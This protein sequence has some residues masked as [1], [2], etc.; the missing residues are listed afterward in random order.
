RLS[1]QQSEPNWRLHPFRPT[2]QHIWS[3]LKLELILPDV[4]L[5]KRDEPLQ[6]VRQQVKLPF[7]FEDW[8]SADAATQQAKLENW[9]LSDRAQKF[10]LTQA[11]LMRVALIQLDETDYQFVWS[12]HH[13]VL[14]A[15]SGPL[16]FETFFA[17]YQAYC[18]QKS[19]VLS[20]SRPYRDYIRWLQQQ[21][22][23]QAQTFWQNKLS[24]I[25]GPTSLR[26]DNN[27]MPDQPEHWNEQTL[28]LSST[29]TTGLYQ[30]AQKNQLTVSTLIQGV[31]AIL[32]SRY[33][34]ETDVV[35][36]NAVSGRTANLPGIE[37]M[38]GLFI[39]MLP[40]RATI[41]KATPVLTW[42]KAFQIAQSESQQ[43]EYTPLSKI[44]QWSDVPAGKSLFEHILLITNIVQEGQNQN[45]NRP[46]TMAVTHIF[47]Q[48]N[49]P[50]SIRV[51]P[52]QQLQWKLSYDCNRFTD[53]AI[54]RLLEHLEALAEN[55][56]GDPTQAIGHLDWITKAERQ[57]ILQDW[58]ATQQ[59][60]LPKDTITQLFEAQAAKT[61][62]AVAVVCD[63]QQLT[64]AALNER[65]NQLA[66][67]LR[68]QG[69]RSGDIVAILMPRS[70]DMLV[71]LLATLKAGAT[72]LP[73]DATY[74]PDRL[75][76]MLQD[77]QASYLLSQQT[78]QDSIP[79][80]SGQT[81]FLDAAQDALSQASPH[82]LDID[83][84]SESLAYVI[85]TS[86]STGKPKGVQIPHR[87]LTN[88]LLSMQQEPGITASDTLLSV[89]TIAFDISALELY[90]PLISGAKVIILNQAAASV[91]EQ[92]IAALEQHQ[93]TLM[94]ATP[95]TWR[96][97][98]ESG[99]T[100]HST[101][102]ILCGGEALK[103]D[104]ATKLQPKG[105]ALWNM[106]GPTE[107]TIW[108]AISQITSD[109]GIITIGRP[110]A[111]TELFILDEQYQP[112]P[113][114]IPGTLYIGGAGLAQGYLNRPNLTSE[115]F[116]PHPFSSDPVAKIYNTGDL[117]RY[118][119]DGRVECLG[120]IDHQVKIRGFRIELEEISAILNQHDA[121][122][123][124]VIHTHTEF[125]ETTLV[126]Y[127]VTPEQAQP[128]TAD[129]RT[130][131]RQSLP[132]YMI[133]TTFMRL[134]QL[135]LTPNGKIDRKALPKPDAA[136]PDL[137]ETYTPPTGDIEMTIAKIWQEVLQ[138]DKVGVH[139]SFFDLGGHSLRMVQVHN[140]L[141]AHFQQSFS[142]IKLFEYPTVAAMAQ[143]FVTPQNENGA[144]S[145]GVVSTPQFTPA[146]DR[147]AR[148]KLARN[149]QRQA[150]PA[151][152]RQI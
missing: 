134:P 18:E 131:L 33:S 42:L 132:E 108:S 136:R 84:P 86:G 133:P 57:Q 147:A 97:L 90:L 99:W 101:L 20:R 11:P 119:P 96:L 89:T 125:G 107:T 6:I 21:D 3:N 124:S 34:G 72:Y 110:I 82:N 79:A 73:L 87:A 60:S 4:F 8:R 43:F 30:L 9:L 109:E 122:Q 115:R 111:N 5:C 145:N 67:H 29:T 23:E 139:D 48:T 68:Q 62:Q 54:T 146:Q 10:T 61:P 113:V 80:F 70:V 76:F 24:G 49:Y 39:N 71:G 50:L 13:L 106:Y 2:V 120:R 1:L 141:K 36:G 149:K 15:W 121:I 123:E 31:W 51:V 85:Y 55:I 93:V 114:G 45:S 25:A 12:F 117:A 47:E 7:Q 19:P 130:Y 92:I 53:E 118:L 14:D 64:Y 151:R 27:V 22:L 152:R 81:L 77:S 59:K 83:I 137:A 26:I 69:L 91:G 88:F 56:L 135:P 52:S 75:A 37:A 17:A 143:F 63:D 144:K 100:G 95:A 148:Q 126:A 129:L 38:I 138:V 40:V 103:P 46:F 104:L 58:N 44:Q 150:R 16:L 98:L 28:K 66:N 116:I 74:P 78:L 112:V 41:D 65:S 105:K 127:I 140:K 35:F 32:L 142:M 128:N 94:Q 102:I